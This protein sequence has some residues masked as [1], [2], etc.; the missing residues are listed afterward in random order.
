MK[1]GTQKTATIKEVFSSIR[2]VYGEAWRYS[3]G[4]CFEVPA[5]ILF[6]VLA[7]ISLLFI[8]ALAVYYLTEVKD[9]TSFAIGLSVLF[10]IYLV[11][12]SLATYLQVRVD[13][14]NTF[15]RLK[16]FFYLVYAKCMEVD[17]VFYEGKEAKEQRAKASQ[18]LDSNW[19]G[20]ELLLKQV[21]AVAIGFI[22][23]TVFLA[24]SAL[25]SYQVILILLAMVSVNIL[26]GVLASRIYNRYADPLSK[27]ESKID[28]LE[29]TSRDELKAKDIRNYRLA[30]LFNDAMNKEIRLFSHYARIQRMAFNL[31]NLSDS[32]FGFLRDAVAY[33]LLISGFI[34]G[35]FS[36]AE[37]TLLIGVVNGLSTYLTSLV[38]KTDDL[39]SA[40]KDVQQV[41]S[42]LETRSDFNHGKG[43]PLS[44]LSRPFSL[45]FRDVSF[46][47]PGAE[48]PTLD[49]LSFAIAPGEKIALV[50]ENGAGKTTIIKL[51]SGFYH[52]TSGTILLDGHPLEELN[53]DD[54]TSLL[55]VIN[56]DV[57][58]IG[59]SLKDNVTCSEDPSKFDGVRFRKA[60][61]ESG[62]SEKVASLPQK[63]NTYLTQNLS[64]DGIL[65]S[66]GE[67]Q[68]LMLAR[69]LYKNGDLLFLDEPTSAL[70]PIAEGQLYQ[71]YA[72]L[73]AGKTSLFISHRL[74]STRFCSR[75]LYLSQGHIQEEGT[76]EELMAKKGEYYHVFTVQA[77]YYQEGN[78]HED[79]L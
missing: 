18:A 14:K 12:Q 31:P 55:S 28:Y 71:R 11:L 21:P 38:S 4:Y 10:G 8:P 67:T 27:T 36:A 66:G 49:H 40:A 50:G 13:W 51:L 57:E 65:L 75:I 48:K 26:L 59:L 43:I 52:P 25:I 22:G 32:L 45:E 56:Q 19:V 1:K 60:L 72:R 35:Q 15:I 74:S 70:D 61:E 34:Q 23:L 29:K 20:V 68:K 7:P 58:V 6:S 47:Y 42:F 54:Y 9:L 44:S 76:H 17:Y 5:D 2:F 62:L 30:K 16:R 37:F 24:S 64:P 79:T 78:V 73:T 41:K 63:E 33:S 46:T 39:L 77:H 53:I 3:H 69:A